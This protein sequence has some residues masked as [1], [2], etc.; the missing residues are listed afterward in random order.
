MKIHTKNANVTYLDSSARLRDF[1]TVSN[2][3]ERQW[4][5]EYNL[6]FSCPKMSCEQYGV[7]N[8]KEECENILNNKRYRQTDHTP[9]S[10]KIIFD[11]VAY[12]RKY[13]HRHEYV[14]KIK[15]PD[16]TLETTYKQKMAWFNPA[17]IVVLESAMGEF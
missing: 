7:V 16:G 6:Y 9:S 3:C 2:Q 14:Q 13:T 15:H 8:P 17:R 4:E 11:N 5:A 12:L 1:L 10:N